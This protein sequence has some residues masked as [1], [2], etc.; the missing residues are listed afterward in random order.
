MYV[1]QCIFYCLFTVMAIKANALFQLELIV[2][3]LSMILKSMLRPFLFVMGN[4]GITK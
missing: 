1:I 2:F 3:A 4:V